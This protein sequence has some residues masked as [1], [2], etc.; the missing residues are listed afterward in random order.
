V[1]TKHELL[2]YQLTRAKSSDCVIVDAE[3]T[4]PGAI[5]DQVHLENQDSR[6]RR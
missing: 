6:I 5:D 3:G 2:K 4:M 1:K